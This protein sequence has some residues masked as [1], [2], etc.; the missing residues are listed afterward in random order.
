[1]WDVFTLLAVFYYQ[2]F[3]IVM[4]CKMYFFFLTHNYI[5]LKGLFVNTQLIQYRLLLCV[6]EIFHTENA[7][8][9]PLVKIYNHKEKITTRNRDY[10]LA[11]LSPISLTAQQW[12]C[13]SPSKDR[14]AKFQI[15]EILN[16]LHL[17]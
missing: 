14:A 1:M 16:L 4:N 3:F 15:S 7:L 12:R 5:L 13:T 17:K 6:R 10:N 11:P 2:S 8:I 9:F